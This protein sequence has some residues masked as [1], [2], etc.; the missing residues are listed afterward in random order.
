MV[1]HRIGGSNSVE[2]VVGSTVAVEEDLE[3]PGGGFPLR[4]VMKIRGD[5]DERRYLLDN[6]RWVARG[7]IKFVFSTPS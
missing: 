7:K 2:P 3:R 6:K 4:E 1:S 5:G